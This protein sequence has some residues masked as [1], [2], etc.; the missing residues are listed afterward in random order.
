MDMPGWWDNA[1]T[2]ARYEQRAKILAWIV[3]I[4][5]GLTVGG[6]AILFN[7]RKDVVSRRDA[8][9]AREK[10]EEATAATSEQIVATSQKVAQLAAAMAVPVEMGTVI[11]EVHD[12]YTHKAVA[13]VI[14]TTTDGR[15]LRSHYPTELP[16]GKFSGTCIHSGYFDTPV[17]G[18][19]RKG[20]TKLRVE[21]E[22]TTGTIVLN[23]VDEVGAPLGDMENMVTTD[24]GTIT[25]T[26]FGIILN[27]PAGKATVS[28][29]GGITRLG[30]E[31][32]EIKYRK[33]GPIKQPVT[34]RGGVE[35]HVTLKLPL[36]ER[37]DRPE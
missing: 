23:F 20:E 10:S 18:D 28:S 27:V 4:I 37:R 15:M 21:M 3:P 6:L 30:N 7:H 26:P 22:Q 11:L 24:H 2:L 35:N 31:E 13:G 17:S 1:A 29:P 33:W 5:S 12:K 14:C 8:E 9:H 25:G 36:L 34:V 32:I 19:V 16:V